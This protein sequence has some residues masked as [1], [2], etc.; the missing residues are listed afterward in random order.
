MWDVVV[1]LLKRLEHAKSPSEKMRCLCSAINCLASAYSLAFP[2][3]KKKASADFLIPAL[4]LVLLKTNLGHPIAQH[5][6][7]QSFGNMSEGQDME[8]QYRV[9]LK[10]CSVYIMSLSVESLNLTEAERS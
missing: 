10:S 1:D 7:V 5:K 2:Y 3:K 9:L 6:F 8:E 4:V